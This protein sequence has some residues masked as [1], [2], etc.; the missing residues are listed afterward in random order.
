MQTQKTSNWSRGLWE[1]QFCKNRALHSGVKRSP[2]EAMFGA[3]PK[4]G[5]SSLLLP[6][7]TI[8]VISTEEELEKPPQM[9][10][11]PTGDD[12]D[13]SDVDNGTSSSN[14]A[15]DCYNDIGLLRHEQT[16][17]P[18]P[19][20]AGLGTNESTIETL[21]VTIMLFPILVLQIA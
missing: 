7:E 4:V 16:E 15:E 21:Q 12:S 14:D 2:Y 9:E 18:R 20:D 6:Q 19:P 10:E 17:I 1:V 8:N 13:N 11:R 3:K 5:L